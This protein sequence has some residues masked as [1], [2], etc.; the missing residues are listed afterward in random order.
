MNNKHYRVEILPH[1]SGMFRMNSE[2][3]KPIIDCI[4]NLKVYAGFSF[5][6][7]PHYE[8]RIMKIGGM[9]HSY[10]QLFLQYNT[11][12]KRYRIIIEAPSHQI[13]SEKEL[14]MTSN[15]NRSSIT[16]LNIVSVQYIL[17]YITNDDVWEALKA[18][19][20]AFQDL[21]ASY[22]AA[23]DR[24]L[25]DFLERKTLLLGE[26]AGGSRKKKSVK[27]QQKSIY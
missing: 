11:V 2:I 25:S 13:P 22:D 3:A 5:G 9:G 23:S 15:Q 20:K 16:K 4:Q 21:K 24:I 1:E 8:L 17:K 14:T 6:E 18:S 27:K 12:S 7:I 19:Y 26:R 10:R